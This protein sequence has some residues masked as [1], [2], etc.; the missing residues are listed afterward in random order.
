MW[1]E[2]KGVISFAVNAKLICAFV[3]GYRL[4]FIS[5]GSSNFIFIFPV[6]YVCHF[7]FVLIIFVSGDVSYL[8]R[9]EQNVG[10]LKCEWLE[11][12]KNP[13]CINIY[14]LFLA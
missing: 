11:M 7:F 5:C 2:N 6:Y 3:F 9:K 13:C 14:D 12:D 8:V 1:S 4:L 10:F